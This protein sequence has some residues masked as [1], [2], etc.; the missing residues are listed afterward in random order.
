MTKTFSTFVLHLF[1]TP[2]QP[3]MM[4]YYPSIKRPHVWN[5]E[6]GS[7]EFIWDLIFGAWNF[8]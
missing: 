2:D 6:F 7:L 3:E 4:P 5:F 1:A 8:H